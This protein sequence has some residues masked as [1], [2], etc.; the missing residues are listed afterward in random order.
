MTYAAGMKEFVDLA[1]R[2]LPTDY[3]T[4]PI[5]RQRQ[6]YDGLTEVAPVPFPEQVSFRDTT[7]EYGGRQA[8]IRIYMPGTRSGTGLLLYIR[9]GGFVLGSLH[10]HHVLIAELADRTGLPTIALD[11]GLAP[12]N[13]FPGP[14]EDCY[15]GMCGVLADPAVLGLAVDPAAAVICGESSGANMAVIV[16]MMARDRGGPK[17]R[18]QALICPVLDFARWRHGGESA[19]QLSGGEMEYFTACYCPKPEQL[20]DPY[21]SPLLH[22]RFDHLPPA[23]VVGCELDSLRADAEKYA[24]LLR[25]HGIGVQHVMRAGLVHAPVRARRICPEAADLFARYCAAAAALAAGEV[26]SGAER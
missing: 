21:V 24:S 13:P 5:A 17:L 22:G 25:E 6:L 3:Y 18:G 1:D 15:A 4:Y 10:S 7:T 12:E 14:P 19:P 11:F 8:R 16:A 20:E 23:Y 26:A 2:A 9:G